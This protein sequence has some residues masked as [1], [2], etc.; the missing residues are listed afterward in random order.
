MLIARI[1]FFGYWI[2]D[3]LFIMSYLNLIK[4][5]PKKFSKPAMVFWWVANVSN[6][7]RALYTI[8]KI[9]ARKLQLIKYIRSYPDKK[10]DFQPE[11]AK[12]K[13]SQNKSIRLLLK[14]CG[15]FVTSSNGWGLTTKLGISVHNGQIGLAGLLSSSIASYE[16][17]QNLK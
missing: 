7:I 2:F 14:G 9:R 6:I 1:G 16:A 15:D 17:I 11:L 3:N 10:K 13:K 5:N 8:S 4:K 12:L